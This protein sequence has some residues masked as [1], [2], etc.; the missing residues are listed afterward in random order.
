MLVKSKK[1]ND[2]FHH[3]KQTLNILKKYMMRFNPTTCTF[4]VSTGSSSSIWS[5]IRGI[6]EKPSLDQGTDSYAIT[7]NLEGCTVAEWSGGYSE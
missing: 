3:V 1:A 7:K 5:L 2:Q 6:K 4:K